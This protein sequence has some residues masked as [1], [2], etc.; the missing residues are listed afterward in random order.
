MFRV[1]RTFKMSANNLP[2]TDCVTF[3]WYPDRKPQRQRFRT[4]PDAIV[5]L[6]GLS[7]RLR[8]SELKTE[9]R[10]LHVN[11]LRLVWRGGRGFAFIHF[12]TVDSAKEAVSA[13]SGKELDGREI[14]VCFI[15]RLIIRV[16]T[17]R[18]AQVFYK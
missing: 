4:N 9:L 10:A 2:I 17:Y 1:L 15:H 7:R 14:R 8:V 6:G 13:L 18:F 5:W 11:P 3:F 12:Q 16:M